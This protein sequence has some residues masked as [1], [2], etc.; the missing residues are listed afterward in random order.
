MTLIF[1]PNRPGAWLREDIGNVLTALTIR[2][3]EPDYLDALR[4]VA[5]A[6]GLQEVP[7]TVAQHYGP[8]RYDPDY[9]AVVEVLP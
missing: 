4:A 9:T 2:H 1:V 3:N 8:V 7:G 5:S 6:L